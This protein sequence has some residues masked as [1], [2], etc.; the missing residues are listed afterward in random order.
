M[1]RIPEQEIERLKQDIS[2]VALAQARGIELK[3]SGADN[4]LG[5]CPFHDD[6]TTTRWVRS[7]LLPD[8]A[9]YPMISPIAVRKAC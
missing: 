1:A 5:L 2:L 9:R 3:R 4:L 8:P 7:C 6:P